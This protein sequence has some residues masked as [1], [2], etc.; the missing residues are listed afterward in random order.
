MT[1]VGKALVLF[2]LV[3]S[4]VFLAFAVMVR[5]SRLE[6]RAMEQEAKAKVTELTKIKT[7]LQTETGELQAAIDQQQAQAKQIAEDNQNQATQLK[8]AIENLARR[9][10]E[11]EQ[12]ISRASEQFDEDAAKQKQLREQ[13]QDLMRQLD[14]KTKED[15]Q[16]LAVRTDLRNRLAQTLNDLE[17]LKSRE[18]GLQQRVAELESKKAAE[19]AQ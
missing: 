13:V 3:L 6:L 7:D 17:S 10:Q 4:I 1:N 11:N 8:N 19:P 15:E 14:E 9:T 12:G 18:Q 16:T 5:V 2:N